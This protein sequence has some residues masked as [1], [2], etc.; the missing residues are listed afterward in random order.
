MCV[1]IIDYKNQVNAIVLIEHVA[2]HLTY[3]NVF[4]KHRCSRSYRPEVI[5]RQ[6]VPDTFSEHGL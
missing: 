2:G 3:L 6:T 5:C 4:K 1:I